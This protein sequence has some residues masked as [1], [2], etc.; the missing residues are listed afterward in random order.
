MQNGEDEYI[1]KCVEGVISLERSLNLYNVYIFFFFA[2]CFNKPDNFR[3][4]I[5]IRKLTDVMP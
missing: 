1:E 5:F 2:L 4:Q 3:R